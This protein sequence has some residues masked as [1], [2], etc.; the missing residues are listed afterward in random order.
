MKKDFWIVPVILLAIV[1]LII[2]TNKVEKKREKKPN[3]L[4]STW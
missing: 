4:Y 3:L 2:V 1:G